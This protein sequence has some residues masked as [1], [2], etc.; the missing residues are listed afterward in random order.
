[1]LLALLAL[2]VPA[3]AYES[4][5]LTARDQPLA[6]ADA[7]ADSLMDRFLERALGRT[8]RRTRCRASQQRTHRILAKRIKRETSGMRLRWERGFPGALGW[9]VF[10][11]TLERSDA[12]RR[13]FDD[14]RSDTFGQ[15][16]F[17]EAGILRTAGIA[18][19]W[20]LGG[21]LVGSDKIAHFLATGHTYWR[22]SRE[23]E[24]PQRAVRR[25]S[26]RERTWDGPWS[27]RVWSFADLRANYDGY[28]FYAGLLGPDSVLQLDPEGCVARVRPFHWADW[29]HPDWDEV[30]NPP[31]FHPKVDRAVK[32]RLAAD[33]QAYC[34]VWETLG[35]H[36]WLATFEGPF[37]D[38]VWLDGEV[39]E[40]RDPW[41]LATLCES[42]P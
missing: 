35:E 22:W 12:P 6:S 1:M 17:G 7:V 19:T 18:S 10:D 30:A 32:R 29:V 39:P 15:V 31:Q 37:P 14:D 2:R 23:G 11:T 8:N 25:G 4:D 16:R 38:V 42:A 20:N 34:N 27:S 9:D 13:N 28:R 5:Q 36:A 21:E 41:G 40:R 24:Q 26:R 3:L 33:R